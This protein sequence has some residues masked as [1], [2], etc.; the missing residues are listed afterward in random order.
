MTSEEESISKEMASGVSG[1]AVMF[2]AY[3]KGMWCSE[4]LKP[5]EDRIKAEKAQKHAQVAAEYAQGGA[6][7]PA[8]GTPE[9]DTLNRPK[10]LGP[11]AMFRTLSSVTL[12]RAKEKGYGKSG[13]VLPGFGREKSFNFAGSSKSSLTLMF[14]LLVPVLPLRLLVSLMPVLPLRLPCLVVIFVA[15]SLKSDLFLLETRKLYD[16]L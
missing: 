15:E 14:V 4:V 9:R 1:H 5:I 13:Q 16:D 6:N 11:A 3:G 12:K 8:D 10:K 7:T 2:R